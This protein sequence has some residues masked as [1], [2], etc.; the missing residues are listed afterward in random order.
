MFAVAKE[1]SKKDWIEYK[2]KKSLSR[3]KN[4]ENKLIIKPWTVHY[5]FNKLF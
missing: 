4:C 2:E 1:S 3:P 5:N